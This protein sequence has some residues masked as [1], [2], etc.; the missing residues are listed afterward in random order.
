MH[1][2]RLIHTDLKPENI[3]LVSSEYVKLPSYK[4]VSS[5]ETQFRCLPKSSAIKLIDFGSTAYDNQNHSS[6]V[7]TRHYRAPEII[8]E[9]AI[10]V[11]HMIEY[12]CKAFQNGLVKHTVAIQQQFDSSYS[13]L[14]LTLRLAGVNTSTPSLERPRKAIDEAY[15]RQY[16]GRDE[17]AQPVPP[18]HPPRRRGPPQAHAPPH[19]AEPF[20]MRDMYMSLMEDRLQSIHKGQV[21]TTDMIIGMCDTPPDDGGLWMNSTL[22]WHG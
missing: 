5:D 2:L 11:I 6:I 1:E 19:D 10:W 20:Q 7:S 9:T 21:A 3:L 12:F 13:P 17:V 8:L 18:Q 15:Y 16:C 14:A 4:R 22:W